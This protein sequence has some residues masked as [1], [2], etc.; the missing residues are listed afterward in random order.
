[1]M[2]TCLMAW[3]QRCSTVF[4]SDHALAP[5]CESEPEQPTAP[6]IP[7]TCIGGRRVSPGASPTQQCLQV[8]VREY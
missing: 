4:F 8:T 7:H 2:N 5:R 3:V 1:M 6:E